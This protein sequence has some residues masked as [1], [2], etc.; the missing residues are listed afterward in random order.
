[1]AAA[2]GRIL[3]DAELHR[4]LSRAARRLAESRYRIEPAVDRYLAIYRRVLTT[5]ASQRR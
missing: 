1:M 3:G 5:P 4:R 2:A